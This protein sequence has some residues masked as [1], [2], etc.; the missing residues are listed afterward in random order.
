MRWAGER[1]RCQLTATQVISVLEGIELI[2]FGEVVGVARYDD[3]VVRQ[4][5][6]GDLR[7]RF[8]GTQPNRRNPSRKLPALG[9]P[10]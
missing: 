6:G 9:V 8:A 1:A 2:H 7:I 10:I 5:D 3:K 4:S